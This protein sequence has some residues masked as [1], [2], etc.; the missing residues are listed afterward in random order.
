MAKTSPKA[1]D[2]HLRHKFGIPLESRGG[3]PGFA[4]IDEYDKRFK[5]QGGKCA[6]CHIPAKPGKRLA[7]DHNHKT[8]RV[9]GLLCGI[10]N[11]RVLGRLE[12]FTWRLSIAMIRDYL[13]HYDPEN[14]LLR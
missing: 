4:G 9:R 13:Q 10:C 14:G 7:I 5:G 6:M 12:R 1:Q 3:P 2:N 11:G 8:S